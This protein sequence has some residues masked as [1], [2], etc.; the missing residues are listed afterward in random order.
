M[1]EEMKV[2]EAAAGFPTP[3]EVE[4]LAL[5][6]DAQIMKLLGLRFEIQDDIIKVWAPEVETPD[7]TN[8]MFGERFSSNLAESMN[9]LDGLK[10]EVE[11][12]EEDGWHWARVVFGDEGELET[13]EAPSKELAGAFACCAALFGRSGGKSCVT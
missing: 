11:F 3:R 4:E 5:T 2:D 8:W 10:V 1:T 6:V 12:F 7:E 9:V 13:A